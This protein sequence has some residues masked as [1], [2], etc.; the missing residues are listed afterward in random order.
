MERFYQGLEEKDQKL[1][2]YQSG[3]DVS[4]VDPISLKKLIKLAANNSRQRIVKGKH[5][6]VDPEIET[7]TQYSEMLGKVTDMERV[8]A[9]MMENSQRHE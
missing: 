4:Y 3:G 8:L 7:Q 2:D 6:K 1:M 5:P 9:S